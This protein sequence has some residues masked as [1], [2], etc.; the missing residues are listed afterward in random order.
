MSQERWD[1]V[2]R[3]TSGPLGFQGDQVL[4]GPVVRLGA[5]PGPGGLKLDGYRGLDDRQ[6]VISAYDGGSVSIGP[7]GTNQVRVA[8]HEN[9]AWA[10]VQ[11]LRAPVY[12]NPGDAFHLGPPGR[13]VT[14]IFVEARRLGLWEQ[15]RI[16]SEAADAEPDFQDSQVGRLDTSAGRPV[17]FI[18]ALLTMSLFFMGGILASVLTD[19][20]EEVPLLGPT[21]E[22]KEYYTRADVA[23]IPPL[24][25]EL[26]VGLNEA[27]H[28]FVMAPNAEAADR[29][30]LAEDPSRWDPQFLDYVQK[31][32]ALHARSQSFWR[33]LEAVRGSYSFVTE[34]LRKEGLPEV[35]AAIPY[36]ESR[37]MS[38]RQSFAC[39]MGWWQLMPE[40][41]RRAGVQV[42]SCR[43]QGSNNLWEPDRDTPVRGVLKNATYVRKL[44]SGNYSCR[45]EGCEVDQRKELAASTDGALA[46]LREAWDDPALGESGALV[47]ISILSHNA[48]YDDS[49]F[50]EGRVKPTNLLQAYEKHRAR[51][52]KGA[53]PHFYGDNITCVGP[54]FYGQDNT[55]KLCGGVLPNE[56]QHYAYS[57]VAQHILAVCYYARNHGTTPP[58]DKWR[59]Y[60]LDGHYCQQI[61]VPTT[62]KVKSWGSR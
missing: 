44:P 37:Y 5:N 3:F 62:D 15:R 55:N 58:F 41:A 25:E 53:A 16:L 4:R 56:T 12:L 34:E 40:T 61:A 54:E 26:R 50:D 49:R 13:G 45:I 52:G 18:P 46:L 1:V 9:V 43:L 31:S 23:D 24:S 14:A 21:D 42:K 28:D 6:A 30:K 35:F 17:W 33:R 7:V 11:T 57:I 36:Q 51:V 47:Q 27:F 22:G 20:Q 19:L 39:A 2:L 48:G 59:T 38:D 32:V 60:L 8:S 10:E 29:P